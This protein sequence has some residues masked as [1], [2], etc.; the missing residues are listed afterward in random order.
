MLNHYHA[1]F[2]VVDVPA[3]V[4]QLRKLATLGHLVHVVGQ[5][6]CIL[7]SGGE[8]HVT[9]HRELLRP[10]GAARH[11][12]IVRHRTHSL[13]MMHHAR[14]RSGFGAE[15]FH[16]NAGEIALGDPEAPQASNLQTA[17][18]DLLLATGSGIV[19]PLR[20]RLLAEV[21]H[22]VGCS[23]RLELPRSSATITNL[24]EV[25]GARLHLQVR[26]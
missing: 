24:E 26:A 13:I 1:A 14:R 20:T 12:V 15:P 23:L 10:L 25:P 21:L 5:S 7:L 2:L 16:I 22:D 17:E 18:H 4:A 9:P 6:H 3:Q 19:M 11:T 8:H